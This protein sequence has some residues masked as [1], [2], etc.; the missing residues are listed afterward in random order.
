MKKMIVAALLS[1]A[2]CPAFELDSSTVIGR[3]YQ[4]F[5]SSK[6]EKSGWWYT[7]T[8]LA[9]MG[10]TT[11]VAASH[12]DGIAALHRNQAA[13]YLEAGVNRQGYYDERSQMYTWKDRR[14]VAWQVGLGL[15]GLG[16]GIMA[17]DLWHE[18]SSR[19]AVMP[20]LGGVVVAGTF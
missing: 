16:L 18:R 19:V 3:S 1:A 2:L 6:K 4:D 11:L 12:F 20:V 9:G 13:R 14:N 15:G 10:A 7:G 17:L 5:M 8:V